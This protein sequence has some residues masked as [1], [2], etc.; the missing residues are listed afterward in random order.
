MAP[1]DL[2]DLT[3]KVALVTGAN[4]GLGFGFASSVAKCNGDVV[5]WSRRADKNEEAAKALLEM[6]AGRVFTQSVDVT[7]EEQVIAAMAE[8]VDEMGRIDGVVANAGFATM[9]PFHEM[10]TETYEALLAVSQHGGFFTIR[11]GVKHMKARAEAG[12]PG[13]SIIVCGSLTNIFGHVGLAHYAA[14][15]GAVAGMMRCIAVEYGNDGIRANMVAAGL[16]YTEILGGIPE[17]QLPYTD[18]LRDQNPIPRWGYPDDLEG[19]TAYLMSDC[20]SYHTG[21]LI[22]VDGGQSKVSMT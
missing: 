4:S 14:A 7:S 11:E 6:G 9:E 21:D 15:K 5:I 18:I 3:G 16:M 8:A 10:K 20:S 12:D 22:V 19:I 1:A 17:D 2:F 13:G